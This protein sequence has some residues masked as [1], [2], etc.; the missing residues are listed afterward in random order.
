MIRRESFSGLLDGFLK[1][2]KTDRSMAKASILLIALSYVSV[3]KSKGRYCFP[4][5]NPTAYTYA[6]N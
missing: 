2:G 3:P 5:K 6:F 1:I 4:K